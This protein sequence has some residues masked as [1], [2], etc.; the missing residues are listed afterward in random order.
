VLKVKPEQ[1]TLVPDPPG[2]LTSNAGWDTKTNLSFLKEV[3]T[4]F[5]NSRIRTSIFVDTNFVNIENA[6]AT[7]TSRIEL[8]TEPYAHNY[9]INKENAI[10]PFKAAAF[11]AKELGLGVNAGHDLNQENLEFFASQIPFLSEVSIGH[12]II[13]DALYLGIENVIGIYK[14]KLNSAV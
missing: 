11:I 13:S 9:S 6:V 3:I 10:A 12:A 2:V 14:R 8:Y 7:G 4:E 5:K 1:V